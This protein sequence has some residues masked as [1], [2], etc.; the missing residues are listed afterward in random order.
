MPRGLRLSM[1]EVDPILDRTERSLVERALAWLRERRPRDSSVLWGQVKR[2][3][4]LGEALERAPSLV[5]PATLGAETRDETTLVAELAHRDPLGGEIALPEKALVA[6]AFLM[7]KIALLRGFVTALRPGAP[8]AEPTL[9]QEV[10]GELAQS[11]YTLMATEIL[12]DLL[13]DPEIDAET[14]ARAAR[15]V[16]LIWDRAVQLE[17]D[18]FCPMLEAA[19]KARSRLA[20]RFGALLGVGE[21]LRLAHEDCP[22]E[23]LEFFGRDDVSPAELEAFEEFLFNLPH[24]DVVKLRAAM[25]QGAH[26]VVDASFAARVLGRP[27]I[28][29]AAVD[30]PEALYRS[31]R[32]RHAAAEFRRVTAVPGPLRVAEAYIMRFVLNKT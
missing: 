24:E 19:W 21:Y 20:V 22:S 7:A 15:Q 4:L 10:R 5:L 9:C 27:L 28:E 11:I 12:L 30:D 26:A 31:Y 2:V 25:K 32:R 23:F 14:K 6:R 3:A 1:P 29:V 18:D 16:V 13:S 17:I 8:G